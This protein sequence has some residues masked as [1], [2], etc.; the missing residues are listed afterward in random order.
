MRSIKVMVLLVLV[1]CSRVW[2]CTIEDSA[3]VGVASKVEAPV[4]NSSAFSVF[5]DF[6]CQVV[7]EEIS[8]LGWKQAFL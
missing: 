8:D 2:G 5:R 7:G 1:V 4:L 3:L 6:K